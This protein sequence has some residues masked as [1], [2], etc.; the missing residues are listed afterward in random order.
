MY[1]I[2]HCDTV[3]SCHFHFCLATAV[4]EWHPVKQLNHLSSASKWHSLSVLNGIFRFLPSTFT[5]LG[6][7]PHHRYPLQLGSS[8]EKS[9]VSLHKIALYSINFLI[10]L[11][12]LG[13]SHLMGTNLLRAYMHGYFIDMRLYHKVTM[14]I[15][16]DS[17]SVLAHMLEYS[18]I[19]CQLFTDS[20]WLKLMLTWTGCWCLFLLFF[21][22][23]IYSRTF[24]IWRIS[25]ETH[26][27]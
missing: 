4:T 10:F 14:V 5:L 9:W 23:Q 13:L 26:P 7:K 17:L 18:R 6:R 11:Y 1:F 20:A 16:T 19:C 2:R 8:A 21:P 3:S 22:G 27:G 25:Q 15:R 12:P 24:C